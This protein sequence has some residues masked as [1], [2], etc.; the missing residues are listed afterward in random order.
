MAYAKILD[1]QLEKARKE[2]NESA[3]LIHLHFSEAG[4]S[5]LLEYSRKVDKHIARVMNLPAAAQAISEA[6]EI[7]QAN[8]HRRAKIQ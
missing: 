1:L 5:S 7:P 6:P 8:I 3:R 4:F 2:L